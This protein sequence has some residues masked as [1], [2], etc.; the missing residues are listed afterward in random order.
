MNIIIKTI[1][2][3][4]LT[5]MFLTL[6]ACGGGGSSP[7]PADPVDT[8]V[9][10]TAAAGSDQTIASAS[11]TV[12]LSGAGT[13]SDGFIN[14]FGWTQTAGPDVTLSDNTEASP[15]F[16]APTVTTDTA[17]V[18]VLT[19]TDN[20]G[21]TGTDTVTVNVTAPVVMVNVPPVANA[22]ADQM[23]TSGFIGSV[24]LS[25]AAS[26]DSDGTITAYSWVQTAGSTVTLTGSNT[27]TPSFDNPSVSVDT[28]FIFELT[29]TDDDGATATD[30]VTI[31]VT[32]APPTAVAGDDQTV[33]IGDDV[34]LA[35]N[36][37]TDSDG[38]V[39]GFNWSQISGPSVTL[40]STTSSISG[41]TAPSVTVDTEFEFE[42]TVTDNSG[43]TGT[44]RVIVAVSAPA[45]VASL[46][47]TVS[48][49]DI[50][51]VQFDWNAI[52]GATF[53]RLLVNP[54]GASG[55]SLQTDNIATNST[56]LTLPVH[57]TDWVN[58]TYQVEAYDGSG[59]IVSSSAFSITSEMLNAVGY[60]QAGNVGN[61]FFGWSTSLSSDGQTLAVGA[62]YEDGSSTGSNG[63]PDNALPNAGAVYVFTLS[64]TTWTQQAY[65]KASNPGRIIAGVSTNTGDKFGTS[66][67]LSADGNT[68][69]V[70]ASLEDS[71]SV[72]IDGVDNDDGVNTGAVYLYRRTGSVP[73]WNQQ[74]YIKAANTYQN[75]NF[76]GA[77]SL[78]ADGNTLAV[79]AE[80]ENSTAVGINNAVTLGLLSGAVYIFEYSGTAWAQQTYIK[81][82][83]TG[84][85][86]RFGAAISLSPDGSTLAVGAPLEDGGTSGIDGAD[87]N[88]STDSGAV[89]VFAYSGTAWQQQAYIKADNA[90]ANDNFGS[91]VSL[92]QDGNLLA[93]AAI[94]EDGSATGING[95]DDD[96]STDSGAVY[97]FGRNVATWSQQAYVKA[98]NTGAGDEF[99]SS[100]SVSA[101][102][103]TLAVGAIN[104]DS[105]SRG[106]NGADD[107]AANDSGAVYAFAFESAAWLQKSFIKANQF[108]PNNR[109]FFGNA[110]SLSAD[111][112]TLIVGTPGDAGPLL[113][114]PGAGAIHMY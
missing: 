8:N 94:L 36:G 19:V 84:N 20:D 86:D 77:V 91:A 43:A 107:N 37:S 30:S 87:D 41:F 76:G 35:A 22:G 68:L 32:N 4:A 24:D 74:A 96:A 89:Y 106:L 57:F 14:L 114:M 103:S 102:G 31:T 3:L 33:A 54:D 40:I 53:Y 83:N 65:I 7:A 63:T 1:L 48:T 28:Q 113:S 17:L 110:V 61:D 27:A 2:K 82:S 10:P 75:M 112:Q 95:A 69:A 46:D 101:D 18:F 56:R 111:G 5:S 67:S 58:A 12:S 88:A 81:A 59:L 60:L 50:K 39:T 108:N 79:G 25:G 98:S 104:E 38:T 64:G 15:T 42:L 9:A 66:V 97:L 16:T 71:N 49:A 21:A 62:I 52:S 92:S 72:E 70:G 85:N 78:S 47:V 34:T 51:T 23:S 73:T 11:G 29:V 13:D 45:P 93:V 99:G 26:T 6:I 100:V 80:Y 90:G 55:F 109:L 44:D 105:N